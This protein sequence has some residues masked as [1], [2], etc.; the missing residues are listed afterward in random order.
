MKYLLLGIYMLFTISGLILYKYGANK[1]FVLTLSNKIF[2]MKISIISI[3]GLL[4]Y[5]ISFLLYMFILPKFNISYIYPIST[6][7]SY[8]GIFILSIL[9][10]G[11]KVS[12]NGIIGSV[13]IL[14]GIIIINW[15]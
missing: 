11:E 3:I 2:S 5:L 6:G 7:I 9:V 12:V 10:L 14:I 15:K 4:C 8:I 13:I 1:A